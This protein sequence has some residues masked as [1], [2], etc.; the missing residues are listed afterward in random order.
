MSKNAKSNIEAIESTEK[1]ITCISENRLI[2][3][4]E[5]KEIIQAIRIEKKLKGHLLIKEGDYVKD[6]FFLIK[7][8]IRQFQLIDGSEKT[9][10]FYTDGQGVSAF[11]SMS[12]K[13]ASNHYFECLEDCNLAIIS[14]EKELELYKKYPNFESLSRTGMESQLGE[15]QD[16]MAKFITLKPEDRYLDLLENRPELIN[17]VPQYHL[18]SYL[19]VS[20]ETLSR[21]RKR[22]AS[23][24]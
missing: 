11:T 4:E 8:C 23:R 24:K 12:K 21:I 14:I 22:I 9:T 2:T 5:A 6:C 19:G 20:P 17:R 1:M 16:M 10:A 13:V 7:G 15:F 3:P 18:A